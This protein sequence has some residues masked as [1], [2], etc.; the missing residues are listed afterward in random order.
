MLEDQEMQDGQIVAGELAKIVDFMHV[1]RRY[2]IAVT[3][4]PE[5]E[6]LLA[7]SGHPA[8]QRIL[9]NLCPVATDPWKTRDGNNHEQKG[10]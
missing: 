6:A 1:C 9:A 2:G 7:K 5:G 10:H 3:A 8:A 4:T